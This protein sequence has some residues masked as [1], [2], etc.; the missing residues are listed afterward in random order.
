MKERAEVGNSVMHAVVGFRVEEEFNEEK[1]NVE[2]AEGCV[3]VVVV[4]QLKFFFLVHF[5]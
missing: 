5:V 1:N 3:L 4:V 2:Y